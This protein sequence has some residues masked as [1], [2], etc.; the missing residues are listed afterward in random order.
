MT[1]NHTPQINRIDDSIYYAQGYN[2]FGITTTHL[3]GR[4][5]ARAITSSSEEF[6]AFSKL[7]HMPIFG[8]KLLRVPY[9][10]TGAYIYRIRDRFGI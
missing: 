8:G 5:I 3:A 10:M 6:D 4:S 1:A 7:T 9:V 2:A